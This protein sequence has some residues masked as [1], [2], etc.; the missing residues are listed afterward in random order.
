MA[1]NQ[2]V[3]QEEDSVMGIDEEAD[4]MAD[5]QNVPFKQNP[6]HKMIEREPEREPDNSGLEGN[7]T[8]NL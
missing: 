2:T 1:H 8:Y 7:I 3:R 6:L 5:S 4:D